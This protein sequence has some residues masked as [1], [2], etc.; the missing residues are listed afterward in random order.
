RG[1]VAPVL[2]ELVRIEGTPEH[3]VR[4]VTLRGLTF[5]HADRLAASDDFPPLQ[6]HWE[7]FDAPNAALRLRHAEGVTVEGCTFEECGGSGLRLDLHAQRH[8]IAGNTFR[9]LGAHGIV[10]CGYGPGTRDVSGQNRIE[11]NHVHHC[12][13]LLPHSSAILLWQTG[14]NVVA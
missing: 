2:T 7:Y 5:A 12:G 10:V 3:P 13:R 14:N 8:R 11:A 4:G 1:V 6:H 9:N